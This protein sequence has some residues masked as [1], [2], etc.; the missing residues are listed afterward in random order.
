[1]NTEELAFFNLQLAGMLRSGIPLEG[2][3][4]QLCRSMRRGPLRREMQLLHED[5]A[6]GTPLTEALASR[7]LPEFYRQMVRVGAQ[8]RDLPGIL[9]QVADYYSRMHALRARVRGMLVYPALLLIASIALS[10]GLACLAWLAYREMG[11]SLELWSMGQGDIVQYAVL[12]WVPPV[13]MVGLLSVGM[14]LVCVP[15]VRDWVNW[16]LPAFKDASLARLGATLAS[17][18]RAGMPLREAIA[19]QRGLTDSARLHAE[20]GVWERVL[21]SGRVRFHEMLPPDSL[22]PPI[23]AWVVGNGGEDLAGGLQ[24]AAD[25]YQTRSQLRYDMFLY[26]L[27]PVSIMILG[28]MIMGQVVV[29][30]KIVV[31]IMDAIAEPF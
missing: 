24:Q 3:I 9:T 19:F 28:V 14:V 11:D 1:M 13:L 16:K 7:S 23:F 21:A 26:A 10:T 15:G 30:A 27:M 17:L 29:M 18:L 5:L 22:V 6:T 2:G 20:M 31:H 8:G 12:F 4:G 25:F